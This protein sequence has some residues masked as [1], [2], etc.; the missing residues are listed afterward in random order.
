MITKEQ[1]KKGC[2]RKVRMTYR[3]Q[4]PF[5]GKEKLCPMCNTWLKG[6]EQAEKY[7]IGIIESFDWFP[8]QE[9]N[10]EEQIKSLMEE[11]KGAEKEDK[12]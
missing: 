5:C 9:V 3:G 2:G 4:F 12:E 8:S 11:I 7:I 10:W 1:I 6:Y